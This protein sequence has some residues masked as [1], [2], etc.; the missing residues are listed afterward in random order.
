MQNHY[1]VNVTPYAL[2]QIQE[3]AQYIAEVLQSSENATRWL[4]T[5]EDALAS[6]SF[7]PSR[8]PLTEEE[9]WHSQGIHKMVV[10]NF[11]SERLGEHQVNHLQ[12]SDICPQDDNASGRVFAVNHIK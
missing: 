5:L 3:T 2:N 12:D 4:D 1:E 10:K 11:L 9:P 8:I 6:L 7:M